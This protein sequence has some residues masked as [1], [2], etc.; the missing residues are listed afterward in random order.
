ME[1]PEKEGR[2][3]ARSCPA[4]T[5]AASPRRR[6]R[7]GSGS[8][9]SPRSCSRTSLPENDRGAPPERQRRL[10]GAAQRGAPPERR[11]RLQG[12]AQEQLGPRG[13]ELLE[14][15]GHQVGTVLVISICDCRLPL[16]NSF[17]TSFFRKPT[18]KVCVCLGQELFTADVTV[19]QIRS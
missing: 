12:A 19:L 14:G 4:P 7:T 9:T 1:S 15:E 11:R 5:R 17:N 6:T 2:A 18:T 13:Q 16:L 10:Q 8:T 3:L